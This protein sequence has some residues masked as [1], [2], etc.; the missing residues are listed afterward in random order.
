MKLTI[1]EAAKSVGKS[2]NVLYRAIESGKISV[3]KNR[4]GTQ[5]IDVSE[6]IRVYGELRTPEQKTT[7]RTG[8]TRQEEHGGTAMSGLLMELGEL[9]AGMRYQADLIA[10]LKEQLAASEARVIA[11]DQRAI[12]AEQRAS[13]VFDINQRLL[14]DLSK[15]ARQRKKD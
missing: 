12:A 14:V 5:V 6:L 8:K 15:K 10:L 9:R 7:E 13:S 1:S 2:R 3:E 11:A 4:D